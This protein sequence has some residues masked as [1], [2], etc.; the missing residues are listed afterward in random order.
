MSVGLIASIEVLVLLCGKHKLIGEHVQCRNSQDSRKKEQK[1]S[2]LMN[3]PKCLA[4][5]I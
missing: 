3:T 5:Q 1:Q 4:I 2:C